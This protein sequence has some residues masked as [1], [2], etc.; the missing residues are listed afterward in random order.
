VGRFGVIYEIGL[1]TVD[2]A[3]RD[4]YVQI[5]KRAIQ[6]AKFPG[7]H[8]CRLMLCIEDPARVIAINEWETL[9]ERLSIRG[10]EAHREFRA[11]VSPYQ[12]Q[13]TQLSHYVAAD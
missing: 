8:C 6:R 13:P 11:T 1:Q 3:Q 12:V 4:E 5:Y 2:P 7:W 9:E 10:T